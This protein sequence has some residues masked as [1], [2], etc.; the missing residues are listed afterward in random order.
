[1]PLFPFKPSGM[2]QEAPPPPYSLTSAHQQSRQL[3]PVPPHLPPR[4]NSAEHQQDPTKS[5]IRRPGAP[6]FR[7]TAGAPQVYGDGVID[8]SGEEYD[9]APQPAIARPGAPQL[10]PGE[11]ANNEQ[12]ASS[13]DAKPASGVSEP[14]AGVLEQDKTQAYYQNPYLQD[15]KKPIAQEQQQ[16]HSY[17]SP[18]VYHPP[19]TPQFSPQVDQSYPPSSTIMGTKITSSPTMTTA[20]AITTTEQS[21][22]YYP[23]PASPYAAPPIAPSPSMSLHQYPPPSASMFSPITADRPLPLVAHDSVPMAMPEP[24]KDLIMSPSLASVPVP[25]LP[26]L[27]TSAPVPASAPLPMAIA[28]GHPSNG[29]EPTAAYATP[30]IGHPTQSEYHI[31]GY[32]PLPPTHSPSAPPQPHHQPTHTM[33][34]HP[35]QPQEFYPQPQHV[36]NPYHQQPG[37][38]YGGYQYPTVTTTAAHPSNN[39]G[40]DDVYYKRPLTNGL[41]KLLGLAMGP[42]YTNHQ[43]VSPITVAPPPI[44]PYGAPAAAQHQQQYPGP[45]HQYSQQQYSQPGGHHLY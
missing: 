36:H 22:I 42:S 34:P 4:N 30:Q 2:Q 21:T 39:H 26:T 44:A 27:G 25:G 33:Y 12:E 18:V 31:G 32:Q 7:A 23:P 8:M 14:V 35:Q 19:A 11:E 24:N 17:T 9:P 10:Y 16:L 1:M 15:V 13:L 43:T 3:Q 28:L 45:Q 6:Q 29:P 38:S 41:K 5:P 37:G 40:T 20:A